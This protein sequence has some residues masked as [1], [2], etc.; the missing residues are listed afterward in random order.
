MFLDIGMGIICAIFV[1]DYFG[2]RL[3]DI[4]L[5]AGIAFSLGPDADFLLHYIKHGISRHDYKHRNGLHFPLLYVPIG[6]FLM[7]FLGGQ[8][9]ATLFLMAS[10]SHFIHDSIAIGWGIKW[11]Y[12]FSKK[13]F[14]FLYHYSK[15]QRKGIRKLVLALDGNRLTE[16]IEEHWTDD[17]IRAIYYNWHPIAIL[18]FSVFLSSFM[19]LYFYVK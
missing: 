18:E 1:S 8:A 17:W 2:V 12:P 13:N 16:M 6:T 4:M 5:L 9:W 14:I 3:T 11:L 15:K 19:L 10:L 7:Y